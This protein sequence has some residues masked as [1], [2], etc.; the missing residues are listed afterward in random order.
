MRIYN[1][2]EMEG[3]RG[4]EREREREQRDPVG[5][6]N[7]FRFLSISCFV[8]VLWKVHGIGIAVQYYR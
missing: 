4:R 6:T 8:F 3:E 2:V 1:K 7:C 5:V